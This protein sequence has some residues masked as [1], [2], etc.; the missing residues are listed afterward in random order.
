M[1]DPERAMRS[2]LP[3]VILALSLAGLE[4]QGPVS[5]RGADVVWQPMTLEIEGPEAGESGAVNP[6]ADYRLDVV[7]THGS[8]SISV[9][10][11]FAADGAAGDS[12]AEDGSRWRVHFVPDAA[13]QWS[14]TVSFR[15]GA[16]IALSDDRAAGTPVGPDGE[17]GSFEIAPSAD[18]TGQLR[19]TGERYLRFAGNGRPFLKAGTDS[20]ENFLAYADFDGTFG[21]RRPGE[22]EARADE[23]PLGPPHRYAPHEADWRNGDPTWRGGRGKGIIGALNYLAGAGVNSVYFLTFNV[24]GD[25]DDVWPYTS[26]DERWRFDCSKL[27]QWETVFSHMDA[28]G[29]QLH[30][31]LTETENESLFELEEG[32]V[33]IAEA[34][35][36]YYRELVARFAHHQAV[37]WNLGEENGWDDR[38]KANTGP[39][40]LANSDEQ[41]RLFADE[42]RR[43]DPWDH[44]IVVHTL[45]GRWADI[46][47]PLLGHPAV[48]GASLQIGLG[49]QIHEQVLQWT[50]RSRD[51]GRPWVVTLDEVG[52]HTDGVLPDA[53]DPDHD[54]VRRYALWGTLMAG[55]AG[56]EWY[57]GYRYP[58][59]DLNAEDFRSRDAMWRQSRIAVDFFQRE[60][61]FTE[62][63][64]CDGLATDAWCLTR[65]ESIYVLY[66]PDAGRDVVVRLPARAFDV[67]WFDPR[68][69]GALQRGSLAQV[70]GPG[71][72]SVGTP[73][74]DADRDWVA[75]LRSAR[76]DGPMAAGE[77]FRAVSR[78]K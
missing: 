19:Y 22:G 35:R 48:D 5:V 59:D 43:L 64:P 62:M 47:E 56:V 57:F 32:G 53:V 8:R 66:V 51:V 73:P 14:Y 58:H 71:A 40:G 29:I 54:Q 42:L 65:P 13:G 72:I 69:G 30:V 60:L 70:E 38:D 7:F 78:S 3:I 20:P 76:R 28:L 44:P 1:G 74:A 37:V 45:P 61:P 15:R 18:A 63:S 12:G 2:L 25:G 16:R 24:A 49:P 11:Y 33:L 31:V 9:P 67:R 23:A 68:N 36:L 52:P 21:K 75:I 55:G 27:D 46:Y 41:R 50:R 10:G 77:G 26:R 39:A 17:H 34:R 4:A 6:F